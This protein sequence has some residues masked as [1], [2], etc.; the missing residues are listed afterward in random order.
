[1]EMIFMNTDGAFH[2]LMNENSSHVRV[3]C[4]L[5]I[6]GLFFF[7]IFFELPGC[8]FQVLSYMLYSPKTFCTY[9]YKLD[10]FNTEIRGPNSDLKS[11]KGNLLPKSRVWESDKE[12]CVLTKFTRQDFIERNVCVRGWVAKCQGCRYKRKEEFP[13]LIN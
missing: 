5:K 1:M 11:T 3:V 7:L 2:R 12:G 8:I 9:N 4:L 6:L 10:R 13:K